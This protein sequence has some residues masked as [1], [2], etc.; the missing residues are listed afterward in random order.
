ML[1]AMALQHTIVIAKV[2]HYVLIFHMVG[3][4]ILSAS[5]FC[6]ETSENSATH[7]SLLG[8]VLF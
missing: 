3:I 8:A 4:C 5:H 2:I 1:I 6:S 7:T